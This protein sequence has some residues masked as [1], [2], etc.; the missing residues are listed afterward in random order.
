MRAFLQHVGESNLEHLDDSVTRQRTIDELLQ[1]LPTDSPERRFFAQDKEFREAFPDGKFNCWA[2]PTRAEKRFQE[3]SVGDLVLLVPTLGGPDSGVH[4]IGIVKAKCP[5]AAY[6]ASKILWPHSK[7]PNRIYPYIFFFDAESGFR[8]WQD[9][10]QDIGYSP[11]FDPRGH[12]RGIGDS[13]LETWGGAQGL[14]THLRTIGKFKL[15]FSGQ[16]IAKPALNYSKKESGAAPA[17]KIKEAVAAEPPPQDVQLAFD[18][19]EPVRPDVSRVEVTRIIRDTVLTRK[20]K[21]IHDNQCQICGYAIRLSNGKGYSEAHHIQPLGGDH[22]GPDIAENI[23]ILCP[24][25]HAEC[26]LGAIK[27]DIGKLRF[28]PEHRV[29]SK[30]ID[31]HNSTIHG[32]KKHKPAAKK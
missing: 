11:K 27:L 13:H 5:V 17:R 18:I 19:E 12:Y 24:N 32:S 10:L 20:L 1:K 22:K 21:T 23:L 29:K 6:D 15:I 28:H 25:H 7:D 8:R 3:T 9:F 16:G 14:L 4:F 26:D 31:Y 30:Y 2:C